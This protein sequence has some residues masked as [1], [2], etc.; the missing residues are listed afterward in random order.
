V[1]TKADESVSDLV[2][3][4]WQIYTIFEGL[5]QTAQHLASHT[6]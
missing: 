5:D 3:F 6:K 4:N 2:N 1:D